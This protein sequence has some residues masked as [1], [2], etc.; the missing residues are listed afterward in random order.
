MKEVSVSQ[1]FTTPTFANCFVEFRKQTR[2]SFLDDMHHLIDWKPIKKILRKKYRKQPV[3]TEGLPIL[4]FPYSSSYS[5]RDSMAKVIVDW[6]IPSKTTSPSSGSAGSLWEVPCPITAPSAGS[7]NSYGIRYLWKAG[8]QWSTDRL[9]RMKELL[10]MASWWNPP[11]NQ[12]MSL[13][14]SRK[15][16]TKMSSFFNIGQICILFASSLFSHKRDLHFLCTVGIGKRFSPIPTV[17]T[18]I[19]WS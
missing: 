4:H 9:N 16:E 19:W 6:S 12:E 13:R 5:S 2:E 3:L 17:M 14:S 1:E 8:L 10:W 7:G 18:T 11:G 15:T